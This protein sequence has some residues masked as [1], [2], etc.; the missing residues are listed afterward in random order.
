VGR[1]YVVNALIC[2]G[3]DPA[4]DNAATGKREGVRAFT[5]NHGEFQLAIKRRT[6]YQLPFHAFMMR[7]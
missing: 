4:V 2:F 3:V 6:I 1:A 5:V 7:Q